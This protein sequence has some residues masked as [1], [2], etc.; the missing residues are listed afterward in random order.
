M[1]S[2][3]VG[4]APLSMTAVVRIIRARHSTPSR[5]RA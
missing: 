4:Q 2:L 5:L 1:R 3:G